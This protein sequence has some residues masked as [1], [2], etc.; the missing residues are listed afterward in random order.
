MSAFCDRR[1][2]ATRNKCDFAVVYGCKNTYDTIA[3]RKNF[4]RCCAERVNRKSFKGTLYHLDTGDLIGIGNGTFYFGKCGCS[5]C[6]VKRFLIALHF[7]NDRFCT[8]R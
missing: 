1:L 2:R 6:S 8:L 7:G 4:V 3:F 5:I